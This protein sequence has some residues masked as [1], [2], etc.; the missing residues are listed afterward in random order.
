[1]SRLFFLRRIKSTFALF[2][3]LLS[4]GIC[5]AQ[6]STNVAQGELRLDG[7][8]TSYNAANG[9]LVIDADSYTVPSG[10]SNAIN[11]AKS[12]SVLINEQTQVVDGNGKAADKSTLKNG[13][14]VAVIG[15]DGGSGKALTARVVI[16]LDAV[17]SAATPAPKVTNKNGLQA[18]EYLLNGQVKGVFSAE[19]IIV[20]IYKRTDAQDKVEELGRP[21]EQ[22]VHLSGNTKIISA[23]DETKTLTVA[24]IKLGQRVAVVGKY[25]GEEDPFTAREMKVAKEETQNLEK[26]GVVRVHPLTAALLNQGEAALNAGAY[27]EAL[28][29]YT[30]A[31]QMAG[32]L[33]DTGGNALAQSY[34]GTVYR[35]LNQPQKALAAYNSSISLS[36]SLGNYS[37]SAVTMSNLGGFYLHQKDAANALKS[38]D[39]ALGWIASSTFSGEDKLKADVLSEKAQAQHDLKQTDQAIGTMRQAIAL[40]QQLNDAPRQQSDF[41]TLA[42]WLLNTKQT[43]AAKTAA[44]QSASFIPQLKTPEDQAQS[45]GIL[46]LFYRLVKDDKEAQSAYDQSKLL[47]TN[48]KDEG[49]LKK[50]QQLKDGLDK[51]DE[52]KQTPK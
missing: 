1:M 8:V 22:K 50:L 28:Q 9:Q 10:K 35:H 12:K 46:Y 19:T 4:C 21:M 20:T 24:D 49:G 32:S 11:P 48:L 40:A 17:S 27:P 18:G 26:V 51:R 15:A 42:F 43:D 47:L 30:K 29:F 31:S 25:G 23:E 3:L 39:T 41:Q 44:Q 36:N 34:L 52:A 14:H 16:L 45:W 5:H 7:S 13:V 6:I 37:A 33:G 38:F 2:A